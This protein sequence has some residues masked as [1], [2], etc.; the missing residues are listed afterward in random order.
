MNERYFNWLKTY[1]ILFELMIGHSKEL[2]LMS[3]HRTLNAT[4][5]QLKLTVLRLLRL[6]NFLFNRLFERYFIFVFTQ[7]L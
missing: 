6:E 5:T 3:T 7:K 2:I 4:P 1:N